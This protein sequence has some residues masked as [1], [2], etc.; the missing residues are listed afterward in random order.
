MKL[1]LRLEYNLR[2]EEYK[3]GKAGEQAEIDE[4]AKKTIERL[5]KAM[6]KSRERFNAQFSEMKKAYETKLNRHDVVIANQRA[7]IQE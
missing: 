1:E 5:E 4:Q 7:V 2:L 3:R 6:E